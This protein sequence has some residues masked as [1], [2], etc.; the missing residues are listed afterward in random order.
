MNP[1]LP[2][3]R[4]GAIADEARAFLR[5]QGMTDADIEA[6]W[7]GRGPYSAALQSATG[8]EMLL[9]IAR[10]RLGKKAL[11]SSPR[12]PPPVPLRPASAP[13]GAVEA[14]LSNSLKRLDIL[15]TGIRS[16]KP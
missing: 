4:H 8:Q 7:E 1:T 10:Q 12:G 11:S 13:V 6:N 2:V 14:R 15:P 16:S 5:E 9:A 3:C